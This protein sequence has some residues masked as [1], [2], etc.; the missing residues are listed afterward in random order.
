MKYFFLL[1]FI[2]LTVKLYNII[3]LRIQLYQ[4]I[5]K[6]TAKY[7]NYSDDYKVNM[8]LGIFDMVYHT[9]SSLNVFEKMDYFSILP[10]DYNKE[11]SYPVLILLHGF[12]DKGVFWNEKANLINIYY[13]LLEKNEIEP[14]ILI[15]P[16]SGYD[17]KSWYTNWYKQ[18]DK[19][20]EDY[21]AK[22]LIES[23]KKNYNTN[24]FAICG[25]S[26]GG[27][28]SLKLALKNLD[29]FVSVSSLAGAINFPRLFVTELKGIGLLRLFKTHSIMT[30]S[31]GS[32]H[33]SN[34]FGE[35]FKNLRKENVYYILR[36]KCKSN[37]EDIKK[38]K[39]LL[40]VGEKDNSTYTMLYQW[41]DVLSEMEKR[42]L[43]YIARIVK[44]E[45]HYW[46]YVEKELPFVLKFHS[47]SF[48]EDNHE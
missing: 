15:V 14:M 24:K 36:K 34:V 2:F 4:F 28:G 23:I 44:N 11:K 21:F 10:K 46:S 39:F 31:E 5:Q 30:R 32:K 18:E 25:F 35:E 41:E 3:F 9:V 22:D 48:L 27:Y 8:N 20:Y 7:I 29:L 6:G 17:G 40:S 16:E 12:K 38:I 37:L 19:K 13:D 33:F 26:M 47:N 45:G 43:N 42:N 1:F